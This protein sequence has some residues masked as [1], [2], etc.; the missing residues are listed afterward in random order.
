MDT[1]LRV[2]SYNI[3]KGVRGLGPARRLEIHNLRS[4]IARLN[5]DLGP[6]EPTK[7]FS[8]KFK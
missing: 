3:H 6:I 4:A 7:L 2:V 5:A 1:A 8:K